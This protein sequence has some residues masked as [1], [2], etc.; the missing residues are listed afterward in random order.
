MSTTVKFFHSD[1]QGAPALS[2]TA[3][4]LIGVLD[5]CLVNGWG[6]AA[7]DGIAIAGGV[8]TVTRA[9]GHPFEPDNVA[10]IAGATVSGGSINGLQKVLTTTGTTWTFDATGLADQSATGAPTHK[11][12]SAGWTK[13]FSAAN[14][15][16]Y[17][18]PDVDGTR[19]YLRVDDAGTTSGRVVGYE[20]MADVNTGT[21]PFP[22]PTQAAGGAYWPKS[23]TAN[24]TVRS[25]V[26]VGNGKSFYLAV[27]W[28]AAAGAS[29][30]FGMCAAFGDLVPSGSTDAYRAFLH[31]PDAS[32][33][34][35]APG[36]AGT[37]YELDAS[38]A[39]GNSTT[40]ARSFSGL[41]GAVRVTRGFQS[42][43]NSA[44]NYRSGATGASL[45]TFPNQSDGGMYVAPAAAIEETSYCYRGSFP[46]FYAIPQSVGA[47]VFGLR[48]R[49]QAV[50][51]LPNRNLRVLNSQSG[52]WAFDVTG[53]WA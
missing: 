27:N 53:P 11:V 9:A 6:T 24:A 13:P 49:I 8:G 16:V 19:F 45:L 28:L 46:G 4:A 52:C 36:G 18:A 5:A 17:R 30:Q 48:G 47:N 26:L 3:G 12:A 34:S 32:I 38:V 25:W 51:G 35:S 14:L 40:V 10:E 42:F 21:G 15:A 39:A 41:G 50:T 31:G 29:S 2:G 7:V 33:V 23:N 43:V 44:G 1:M 37:A 22:T 20:T